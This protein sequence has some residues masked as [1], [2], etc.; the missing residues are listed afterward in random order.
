VKT[1]KLGIAGIALVISTAASAGNLPTSYVN[2][3]HLDII[4]AGSGVIIGPHEVLTANHV[5]DDCTAITVLNH[6]AYV[7]VHDETNDLAVVNTRDTWATWALFSN[8]PVH[9]GDQV[10]AMGY[11]LADILASTASVSV[12]NVSALAGPTMTRGFFNSPRPFNPATAV[13]HCSIAMAASSALP[14]VL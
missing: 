3:D 12:G 5:V 4:A 9:A 10:V 1:M 11:P 14:R 8:E 6:D 7:R 13:A 2:T